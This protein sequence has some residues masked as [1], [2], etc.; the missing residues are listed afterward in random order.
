MKLMVHKELVLGIPKINIEG[1][2]SESC[3]LGKD[4]TVVS[5]SNFL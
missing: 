2:T 4:K 3:L 5:V 1:E